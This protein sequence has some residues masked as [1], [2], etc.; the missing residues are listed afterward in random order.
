MEAQHHRGG[1]YRTRQA[2]AEGRLTVG[3]IGGSITAP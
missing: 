1:L 3:F 2:L